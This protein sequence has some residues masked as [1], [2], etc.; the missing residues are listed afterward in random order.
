ML[1]R[2]QCAAAPP[3][4]ALTRRE[5]P[6][7]DHDTARLPAYPCRP[8]LT[9]PSSPLLAGRPWGPGDRRDGTPSLAESWQLGPMQR[10]AAAAV[11]AGAA[12]T[13]RQLEQPRPKQC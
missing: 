7:V 4:A 6:V 13:W 10:W 12:A 11:A 8:P 2:A 9:G 3:A 5:W 1:P